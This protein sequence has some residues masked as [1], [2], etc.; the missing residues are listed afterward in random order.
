MSSNEGNEIDSE[1]EQDVFEDALTG[2]E[3]GKEERDLDDEEFFDTVESLDEQEVSVNSE[4]REYEKNNYY[5]L[6][7][8]LQE[9]TELDRATHTL[10]LAFEIDDRVVKNYNIDLSKFKLCDLKQNG[11]KYT[12][13]LEDDGKNHI[14]LHS[15]YINIYFPKYFEKHC[16]KGMYTE[17]L[18]PE[19]NGISNDIIIPL[20]VPKEVDIFTE[21][22]GW[23]NPKKIIQSQIPDYPKKLYL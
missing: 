21:Q 10:A 6:Q 9:K 1:D 11:D 22:F 19:E 16:E 8:G 15:K 12:F 3:L 5:S 18:S 17:L 4:R 14:E 20:Q 23:M 13:T 2:Q 7:D